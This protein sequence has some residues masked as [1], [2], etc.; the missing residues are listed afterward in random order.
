[1]VDKNLSLTYF[2]YI[3]AKI[4]CTEVCDNQHIMKIEMVST[5][6]TQYHVSKCLNIFWQKKTDTVLKNLRQLH[7]IM[8]I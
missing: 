5:I 8:V 4:H 3:Y 2:A 7:D 1:M 6:L